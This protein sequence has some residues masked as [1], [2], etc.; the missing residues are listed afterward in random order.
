MPD[1]ANLKLPKV[2]DASINTSVGGFS[3]PDNT[4]LADRYAAFEVTL[5]DETP[6]DLINL[7][8][9]APAAVNIIE[10]PSFEAATTGWTDDGATNTKQ[11]TSPK[12]GSNSMR[13]VPDN[14][15]ADE[16]AYIEIV[17]PGSEDSNAGARFICFS[18]DALS[19]SATPS[20]QLRVLDADGVELAQKSATLSVATQRVKLSVKLPVLSGSATY[21]IWAGSEAQHAINI[22]VDDVQVE[23]NHTGNITDYINTTTGEINTGWQGTANASFSQRVSPM[24]EITEVN[25]LASH[26]TRVAFDH[27]AQHDTI[28]IGTT[29][30][31][32]LIPAATTFNV[33]GV[34][35]RTRI[36]ATNDV[37]LET[38]LLK[39]YVLG[40]SR[41]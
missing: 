4:R 13:L 31:G 8:G 26:A 33:K 29:L 27:D 7:I 16:G 38:P 40:R 34:S 25:I 10:N 5:V 11:A 22:F 37:N 3:V 2:M 24:T 12:S 6:V 32:I 9:L 30:P 28:A 39:G 14:A 18:A 23:L 35:I 15:A 20:F 19:A 21:R 17:A 41:I 36:N 1:A